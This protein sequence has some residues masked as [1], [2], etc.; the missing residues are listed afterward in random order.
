MQEQSDNLKESSS[1]FETL[2]SSILQ[3]KTDE[4]DNRVKQVLL[5]K[6][7]NAIMLDDTSAVIT[8]TM[9]KTG[10]INVI[11]QST[12]GD[13][14]TLGQMIAYLSK[15]DSIKTI[16]ENH[17]KLDYANNKDKLNNFIE[18]I[19]SYENSDDAPFMTPVSAFLGMKK[20]GGV[21]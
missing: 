11:M 15:D 13:E 17:V 5:D 19:K 16:I 21:R 8:L 4:A 7:T 12:D 6:I 1:E 14:F 2:M 20:M 3:A 10:D 9:S 18:G